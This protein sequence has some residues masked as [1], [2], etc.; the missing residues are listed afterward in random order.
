MKKILIILFLLIN[1]IITFGQ[2]PAPYCPVSY[3]NV[4]CSQP[5]PSNSPGNSVNDF[6]NSFNTVGASNNITN[7]NSGCNGN[8]NNYIRY[9]CNQ[10]FLKVMPG[11]TITCNVQSGITFGQGFAV[12]IDW[13][14]NNVFDVPAERVASTPGVPGAG[15]FSAINFTV[16]AGQA[17]GQYRLRVRSAYATAGNTIGPCQLYGFGETEDYECFVNMDPQPIPGTVTTSATGVCPNQTA[18]LTLQGQNGTIQWQSA[19]NAGG[20]WTNVA[21]ATTSPYTTPPFVASTC[22]RAAL[23]A[24]GQTVYTQPICITLG[25]LPTLSVNNPTICEGDS[26]VIT[27]NA[28]P[29][30]GTYLWNNGQT[31]PSITVSPTITTTYTVTYDLGGCIQTTTAVVNVNPNP[32]VTINGDSS[33]CVGEVTTLTASQNV[34][35]LWNTGE[36]TQSINVT[37]TLTTVYTVTVVNTNGCISTTSDTIFVNP[38]PNASFTSDVV[39]NGNPTTL[40][41]TSTISQGTINGYLWSQ[42]L[43]TIGVNNTITY[44]FQNAGTFPVTLTLLSDQNCVSLVTQ[45]VVVNANPIVN[46]MASSTVGCAPF[47]VAFGDISTVPNSQVSNWSWT[48][49]GQQVSTFPA[50]TYCFDTPGTY[51]VGLTATS[52]Q[53]CSST[54]EI[55]NYITVNPMPVSS[56]IIP[57]DSI[58]LSS[59][60]LFL[61]N[62]SLNASS[63]EWSFGDS[64][65]STDVNPIHTYDNTGLYCIKLTAYGATGCI[66]VFSQC[67]YIYSEFFVYIPNTFTPNKDGLN[68]NFGVK[69]VGLKTVKMFVYDRWG[70]K[71]YESIIGDQT[72]VFWNGLLPDGKTT[73]MQDVYVYQIIVTDMKNQEHIFNGR[74]HLIK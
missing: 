8:P 67:L 18:T 20:P 64:T 2:S 26:T 37:P 13:N 49:N 11:Q 34:N 24:C 9:N 35:Y 60:T 29:T 66:D 44:P 59:A 56:F 6:I 52:L 50:P 7:N 74:V 73:A 43:N 15:T 55:P 33:I 71:V 36:Q 10:H 72:T 5:G 16:P 40:V 19:P 69:G 39:C 48:V 17:T 41:S 63:Y 21:G 57:S 1:S 14:Q 62:Q 46:F 58:P 12:F 68:E 30:G 22:Y 38:L 54:L 70:L 23:T 42:N 32:A 53:G 65:T 25:Q 61:V 3:S 27:V 31:T 45:N 4:T 47:C 28:T 51:S